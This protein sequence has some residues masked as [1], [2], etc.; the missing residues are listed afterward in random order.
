MDEWCFAEVDQRLWAI[1][2]EVWK[3]GSRNINISLT[4]ESF[5]HICQLS[6]A[7]CQPN[8]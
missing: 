1:S 3:Y 5:I 6:T 2:M 4:D 8:L 7:N